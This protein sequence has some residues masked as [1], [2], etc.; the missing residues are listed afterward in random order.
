MNINV[1][2]CGDYILRD[3]VITR[4]DSARFKANL[5][6]GNLELSDTSGSIGSNTINIG[7]G[8]S[9]SSSGS[10]SGIIV[11]GNIVS[12]NN[13]SMSMSRKTLTV[14]GDIDKIIANGKTYVLDKSED[15]KTEKVGV[16]KYVLTDLGVTGVA[17]LGT[18]S[19]DMKN[20][21]K[22]SELLNLTI[23]GSG[24]IFI[25]Y[26]EGVNCVA[27][28]MG[29][30]DILFKKVKIDNISATVMGA[31][32]IDSRKSSFKNV[33]KTIMGVGNINLTEDKEENF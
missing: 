7:R 30:G 32:D 25:N 18:G 1:N 27:T 31:G 19:F 12:I 17:L 6:G 28:I 9:I 29:A 21:T 2:G 14:K 26:Y 22:V 23:K 16:S 20:G 4:I 5:V 24:D 3:G 8:V 33:A 11:N 10:G 15:K 13:V